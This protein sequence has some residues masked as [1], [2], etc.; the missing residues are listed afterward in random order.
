MNW[1]YYRQTLFSYTKSQL[2]LVFLIITTTVITGIPLTFPEMFHVH[3]TGMEFF[4]NSYF[5]GKK[6]KNRIIHIQNPALSLPQ[7][8]QDYMTHIFKKHSS[9]AWHAESI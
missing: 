2:S 5:I 3:D 8:S 1:G 4:F 9:S 7:N 6:K